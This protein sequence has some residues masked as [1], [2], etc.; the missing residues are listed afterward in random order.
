MASAPHPGDA[1]KPVAAS[2]PPAAP[3]DQTKQDGSLEWPGS[4]SGAEAKQSTVLS[5][6]AAD[7]K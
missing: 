4:R 7:F 1:G 3:T 5:D 6:V 2:L